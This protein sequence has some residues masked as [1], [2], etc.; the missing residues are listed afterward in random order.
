MDAIDPGVMETGSQ[1]LAEIELFLRLML[2]PW[3]IYQV[4]ILFALFI[5]AHLL[6]IVLRGRLVRWVRRRSGW[7]KWRLRVAV[8]L[9]NRMRGVIFV[10]LAWAVFLVMQ[11]VTWPS[12][13]YVIGLWA[14]IATAWVAVGFVAQFVRNRVI[15][16]LVMWLAWIYIG[17]YYLGF[18]DN[19][20]RFLDS[21]AI[22]FAD[23]RLTALSIFRG[24]LVTAVLLYFARL[25]TRIL[26]RRLQANE[27]LSPSMR[28]LSIKALKFSFIALAI[29]IGLRAVGFDLTGLAIL[30]GAIGLGIG[31]GLQKVV[32]NLVSGVI[33]LLD[34]SVKPGDVIS[35]GNTFGWIEEL[36]ARYVSVVT[37]DGREY[38]IPN[39]DM[40]TNQVVNWSHSDEFVRI[41]LEF[42]TSYQDDP[43][44][45]RAIAIEA[46]RKVPRVLSTR[47]VVCHITGF[48]NSSI[49][50]V[51]RFWIRDA[52]EGLQGVRGPVFLA[53]WDAFKEHGIT[54]PFPQREVRVLNEQ[55]QVETEAPGREAKA[56]PRVHKTP[57]AD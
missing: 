5:V 44:K 31:F 29:V 39:E 3:R 20:A 48:G 37:R 25:I 22:D 54:I 8:V 38:L 19:A 42:G 16:Y 33:I 35:L 40:V 9:S 30:S 52:R 10:L 27:D 41:D 32:S 55:L 34:R 23:F 47:P 36:G 56:R 28:V 51:L 17:L 53:L 26:V 1:L 21:I 43:H 57:R 50:Y 15:R 14:T 46:A 7:P 18:L 13:S 12:R 45:V 24:L 11:Q 49:D 2:L 4:G 6:A